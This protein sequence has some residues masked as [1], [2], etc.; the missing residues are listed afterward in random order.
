MCIKLVPH[1]DKTHA[2]ATTCCT[3][4]GPGA[5][6]VVLDTDVKRVEVAKTLVANSG[7]SLN[8]ER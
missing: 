7:W 8:G 4:E 5:E 1:S 3:N 2:D 6:L